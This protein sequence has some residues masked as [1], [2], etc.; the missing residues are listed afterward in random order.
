[1]KRFGVLPCFHRNVAMIRS[2]CC[3]PTRW[4][5]IF[6]AIIYF[7]CSLMQGGLIIF[8]HTLISW[9]FWSSCVLWLSFLQRRGVVDYKGAV[10]RL[11]VV[12]WIV[13]SDGGSIIQSLN[14]TYNVYGFC[15]GKMS[16]IQ[17]NVSHNLAIWFANL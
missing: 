12:L 10:R 15:Q 4:H 7:S 3:Q 16:K 6:F 9:W 17:R 11:T 2:R 14:T 5:N 8:F 13:G 1:M